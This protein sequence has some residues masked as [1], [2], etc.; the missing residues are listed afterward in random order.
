MMKRKAAYLI[1]KEA[2]K[3]VLPEK[4]TLEIEPTD[5]LKQY[6]PQPL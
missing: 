6:R 3:Y 1:N 5:I 4:C 2:P